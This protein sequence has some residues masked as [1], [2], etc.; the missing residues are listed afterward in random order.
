MERD[1]LQRLLDD[2]LQASI[3]RRI[4]R[5][6]TAAVQTILDQYRL[7]SF[8]PAELEWTFGQTGRRPILLVPPGRPPVILRGKIDRIDHGSTE[9]GPCFRIVDYKSGRRALPF[10]ELYNGLSLQLP[11]YLTAYSRTCP[12]RMA[13]EAAYFQISR[14]LLAWPP[15]PEPSP[16][17]IK[18]KLDQY[19]VPQGFG[20]AAEDLVRICDHALAKAQNWVGE[21]LSGRFPA[22]PAKLPGQ[23]PVCVFCRFQA[24]CG[25]DVRS[26]SLRRLGSVRCSSATDSGRLTR[27]ASYLACLKAGQI[28]EQ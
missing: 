27:R 4:K 20:V 8:Q 6:A 17:E 18:Q 19:Y 10:D 1:G 22:A 12:S 24:V 23:P 25:F 11:L 26:G 5:T 28:E 16:E 14:P 3:G 7:D 15:G 21:L 2:G 13:L 9:N